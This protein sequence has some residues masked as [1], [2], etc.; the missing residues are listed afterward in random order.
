MLGTGCLS[1]ERGAQFPPRL[2]FGWGHA[3]LARASS[4]ELREAWGGEYAPTDG[5]LPNCT[6]WRKLTPVAGK[7][8]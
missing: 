2:A 1:E 4:I 7:L 6:I 3:T 8:A 5:S